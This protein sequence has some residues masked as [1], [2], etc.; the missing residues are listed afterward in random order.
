MYCSCIV[1]STD[2]EWIAALCEAM[3]TR[4]LF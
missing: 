2:F 4:F 3:F 1:F